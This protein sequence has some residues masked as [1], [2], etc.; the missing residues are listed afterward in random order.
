MAILNKAQLI[1]EIQAGRISFHPGID[2]FQLQ[3]NAIDLRIGWNFY[4]P[5]R[6]QYTDQ[7]R[8]AIKP[9]YFESGFNKD[10]FKLIKLKAG[11][12]FEILPNE[13]ILISTLEKV[14]LNSNN[15]LAILYPRSSMIRRGLII[16]SGI[17]DVKYHGHLIIPILNS[18]SHYLTL[19]PGER[20]CQ[21][22]FHTLTSDIS[23][24]D[25]LQHGLAFAKYMGSTP[26]NLEARTDN[27]QEVAF[28]KK[29]D[30]DG[31]KTK[32]SFHAAPAK[33]TKPKRK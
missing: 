20:A 6:W 24:K 28:I 14:E 21:L 16:E 33:T 31:L 8:I 32:F 4:I 10:Y 17:I 5:E 1:E 15:L 29:G 23:D 26:Y 19:Y 9:D 2:G 3:P 25:A 30:V 22:I 27:D 18:T 13:F 7:G 11:Q 12:Y